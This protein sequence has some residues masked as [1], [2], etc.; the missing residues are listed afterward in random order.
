[1]RRAG[2]EYSE[3]LLVNAP[4]AMFIEEQGE[5]I[6]ESDAIVHLADLTR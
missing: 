5:K 2:V 6:I 1:M 4:E 3:I